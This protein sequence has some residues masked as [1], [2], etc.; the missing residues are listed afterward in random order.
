[1]RE[2][3][4][5]RNISGRIFYIFSGNSCQGIVCHL[6][7]FAGKSITEHRHWRTQLSF[8]VQLLPFSCR[9]VLICSVSESGI[10]IGTILYQAE[11][12]QSRQPWDEKL[13]K[14]KSESSKHILTLGKRILFLHWCYG[15]MQTIEKTQEQKR[16]W[17]WVSKASSLIL[18]LTF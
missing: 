18:E 11:V 2:E 17:V 12:R 14:I 16:N 10:V 8:P 3:M 6:Q 13:T 1:M 5:D 15:A 4:P 7:K 9:G